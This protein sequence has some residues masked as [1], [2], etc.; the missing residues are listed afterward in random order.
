MGVHKRKD[1][2]LD[3]KPRFL[4]MNPSALML[5]LIPLAQGA[6]QGILGGLRNLISGI[7]GGLSGGGG[8]GNHS[9]QG[10]QYLVSWRNGRTSFTASEGAAYCALNGMRPISLDTPAKEREFSS[11]LVR[12]RQPY[13]WTG[14]R[15]NH[16]QRSVSWPSGRTTS[17]TTGVLGSPTIL[18]GQKTASLLL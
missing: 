9:F 18:K 5:L 6:P 16:C 7:F 17:G 12:E 14:G 11:L 2:R 8:R 1:V 13:F 3:S 15:V 4:K 10:R